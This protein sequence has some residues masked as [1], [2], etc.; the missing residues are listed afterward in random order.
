[1]KA[2][3]THMTKTFEDAVLVARR[4][5]VQYLWI[6]SFCIVQ[7]DTED[8]ITE[9]ALMEKVY[10]NALCNIAAAAASD[11]TA[12]LFFE[13]TP[14]FPPI[15]IETQREKR[16]GYRHPPELVEVIDYGAF[17]RDIESAP[18]QKVSLGQV[19]CK[20]RRLIHWSAREAGFY[21]NECYHRE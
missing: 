2:E 8:W 9:S 1:M 18:L 15:M 19:H 21:K 17:S 7:D 10:R 20:A 5:Q 4:L 6:D 13:R 14:L 16:A 11:G 12:G 3:I